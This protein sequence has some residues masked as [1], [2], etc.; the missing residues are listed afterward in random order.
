MSP[1][2]RIAGQETFHTNDKL[3]CFFRFSF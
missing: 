1:K 3:Y 2:D